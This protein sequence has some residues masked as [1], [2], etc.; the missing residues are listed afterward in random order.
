MLKENFKAIANSFCPEGELLNVEV[1]PGGYS[2]DVFILY[3]KVNEEEVKFVLRSEGSPRSENTINTEFQLIQS[4]SEQNLPIPEA[5]FCDTSLNH[6]HKP[7][8]I[9]SFIE[10]RVQ[11]P[12]PKDSD[13][14]DKF[15]SLLQDVRSIDTS[16]LPKLPVRVD[17]L[18]DIFK[19]IPEDDEWN[20]LKNF[21]SNISNAVYKGDKT[22]LHGDFW[23]GNIL[24]KEKE[25]VGLLDWEYAAIGD[26][27][28]DIAVASLELRYSL[29]EEGMTKFQEQ[30]SNFLAIDSFRLSLWMIYVAS[31]TLT[32]IKEW[33]L[34]EDREVIM[35]RE[36]KQTIRDAFKKLHRNDL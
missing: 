5:V 12:T 35:I 14:L 15:A 2:S 10:G 32:Y 16:I 1:L 17:P 36:A 30:C 21:L 19:F 34:P 13:W 23:P 6:F 8:M 31:S 11:E 9:M 18:E 20:D 33:R 3:L 29:G 27:V 25:I 22:F 24:W 7:F 28:S 4:L 26:P